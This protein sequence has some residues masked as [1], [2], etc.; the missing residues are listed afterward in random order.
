MSLLT[1]ILYK[2]N[3]ITKD[4]LK[5]AENIQIGAKKPIQDVLV[6]EGFISDERIAEEI[7]E[8]YN[9]PLA[10]DF[11]AEADTSVLSLIPYQLAKKYGVFPIKKERDALVLAMSDPRDVIAID[12]IRNLTGI[13]IKPVLCTK[14][15][16]SENIE[17]HYQLDDTLYDIMKNM[18]VDSKV[19]IINKTRQAVD[20]ST[21]SVEDSPVV[22]LVSLL[23]TDA[24]KQRVSDIHIEPFEKY[25]LVRYRI[26]GNLRKVMKIPHRLAERL[27]SR[28]KILGE[29]D[30]TK[31][32]KMQDGR[33]EVLYD[34]RKVDIRI[35]KI[36][37][38]HGEKIVLRILDPRQKINRLNEIG[39]TAEEQAYFKQRLSQPQGM[40]LVTGPTGSGKSSTLNAC[41]NS[42]NTEEINITTIEDPIEYLMPGINQIQVNEADNVTFANGLRSILRQDP[43]VVMI[44]EIRDLETAE[45]AF[46]ASL[47]GHLVLSTLHTNDSIATVVRLLDIGLEAYLIATSIHMI[48]A[49]RLVRVLCDQCKI[50][51]T[52][53]QEVLNK[54]RSYMEKFKITKFY[55]GKGCEKCGYSGYYGRTGLFEILKFKSGIK[56]L[57]AKR[58]GENEILNEA[59]KNGFTTMMESGFIKVSEG[60]TTIDEVSKAVDF[61]EEPSEKP[62]EPG[63][64]KILV[65]DDEEDMRMVVGEHLEEAGF[66]VISAVNGREGVEKALKESPDLIIMDV[67]M[68]V[69]DGFQAVKELRSEM[70]TA[71]IPIIMLTAVSDKESELRG[72]Q[73]G[74]DDYVTKPFDSDMLVARVKAL[75]RRNRK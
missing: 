74:A 51:Y 57:V 31:K 20:L 17:T 32:K 13:N 47:T 28:I 73:Y 68:P 18:A 24:V 2:K 53:E 75:L 7:S 12:D 38:F 66:K 10:K 6:D 23:I 45:I 65:V 71:A 3:L 55:K 15:C 21:N 54:Y 19:E 16:I 44:G 52:P 59:K 22:K 63:Q 14:S 69:M 42:L 50:E 9:A 30:I 72:L 60:I 26:D 5:Q 27:I 41:L 29:I 1:D 4:Q 39:L 67:M 33:I 49:Q 43:N 64:E 37:V 35:S 56:D 46:R 70:R 36:P 58:A 48:V 34:S 61:K 25:Y 62:E 40:I 8:V 11:L